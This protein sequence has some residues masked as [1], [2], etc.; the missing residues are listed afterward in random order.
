MSRK[1]FISYRR[2]DTADFTVALYNQLRDYFHDDAVFK[3]I[4]DIPPGQ[5]F[6]EVLEKELQG[7]M[8]VLVVIG[9][10]W[11]GQTT[12]RLLD[13]GDWV[14]Q[15]VAKALARNL[16]VVPIL[17]NGTK[18][19]NR[20]QLPP[21][22]H[23]LL[24]RQAHPIDNQRFEYDVQRLCLAIQDLVPPDK[25]KKKAVNSVW[26]HVF[27]AILLLFMLGSISLIGWAWIGAVAEF[28]EKAFMSLIG[29]AGMAG[30]WAAFTRQRWIE[31]RS[32]QL[33]KL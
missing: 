19:P 10:N 16:R 24:S 3:D 7:C 29:V 5:N 2:N 31:L 15:E 8:V 1:I 20:S 23:P 17:A 28:K 26:D 4:N 14:R 18:M 32:N 30:G 13:E 11:M 9:P 33:E 22:L 25:K 12:N 27:K 6:A 21:D